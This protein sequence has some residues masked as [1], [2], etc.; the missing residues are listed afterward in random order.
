MIDYVYSSEGIT[1]NQLHGFFVG[2]PNPPSPEVH[3]Q[4]LQKSDEVILAV[5]SS[6]GKIIGFITAITDRVLSAY[7]PLLEVLPAYQH[8]QIGK[9]LVQKMLERLSA[10][11]MV[12]LLC[13]TELQSFYEQFEMRHASGMFL[14]N[15]DKQSGASGM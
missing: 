3:L 12:D 15:Y 6:N 4:L 10:Y 1:A 8:Q 2:W 9:T 11:Y 14:R 7:I 5:D 13:D